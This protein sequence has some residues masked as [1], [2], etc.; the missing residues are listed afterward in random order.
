MDRLSVLCPFGAAHS[1][2]RHDSRLA[3]AQGLKEQLTR[4]VGGSRT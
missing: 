4:R 2:I 3:G 1:A